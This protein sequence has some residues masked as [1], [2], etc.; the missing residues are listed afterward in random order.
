MFH[1]SIPYYV[2]VDQTAF[3]KTND[4][5]GNQQIYVEQPMEHIDAE[6]NID[7]RNRLSP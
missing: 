2:V 3:K 7:N 5:L 1:I 4:V 6:G